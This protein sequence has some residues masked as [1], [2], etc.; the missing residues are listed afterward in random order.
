MT[1]LGLTIHFM[2]ETSPLYSTVIRKSLLAGFFTQV[3]HL[4]KSGNYMVVR[5]NQVVA[6][7]PSSNYDGRPEFV[8]YHEFILTSRN[9]V[10]I[11][12][13]FLTILGL[14]SQV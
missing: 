12:R 6:V 9:Y 4:Q 7:H 10:R 11:V 3:A 8:L 2:P 5:D 13:G 14:W 1:R